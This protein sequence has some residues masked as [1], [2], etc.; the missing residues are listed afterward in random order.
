MLGQSQESKG[1]GAHSAVDGGAGG[2]GAVAISSLQ[3]NSHLSRMIGLMS[4][5]DFQTVFENRNY[6]HGKKH[7]HTQTKTKLNYFQRYT[8]I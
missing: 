5:R 3:S 4:T 8:Y 2:A 7:K 1:V 6:I